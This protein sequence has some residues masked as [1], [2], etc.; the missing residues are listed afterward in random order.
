ML[1][2]MEFWSLGV[3]E[4]RHYLCESWVIIRIFGVWFFGEFRQ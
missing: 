4:F 2:L 1:Y 3:Q